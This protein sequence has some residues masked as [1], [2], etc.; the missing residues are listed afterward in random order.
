MAAIYDDDSD[1]GKFVPSEL[2]QL[3][4]EGLPPLMLIQYILGIVLTLVPITLHL[5]DAGWA[6]IC[7]A[8][9][10]MATFY[11][12]RRSRQ[13]AGLLLLAS[14]LLVWAMSLWLYPGDVAVW[15]ALL[16]VGEA[17][18]VF[19]PPGAFATSVLVSLIVVIAGSAGHVQAAVVVASSLLIWLNVGISWLAARPSTLSL[20]W[21]WSSYADARQSRDQLRH[22]QG[23]LNRVLKSL[24]LAYQRLEHLSEELN[25]ARQAAEEA[26]RLKGEFAASIS[27]ELRTPL[28]LIIG[29]AEMMLMGPRSRVI[30]GLP[31]TFQGDVEAIYRNACH[32]SS[33]VDDILDLSQIDAHRMGL[34]REPVMLAG[35]VEEATTAISTM[36]RDKGLS[37]SAEIPD[38]LPVVLADR[39]RVRQVLINLL[40]NAA[41]FTNDGGVTIRARWD[42]RD[43]VVSVAD[44]GVGLAPEDLP[45]L[46]DEFR[47]VGPQAS[48]HH[49]GLGLTICKR[50]VELHGG[51]I[52]VESRLGEGTTFHFSLPRAET[53]VS[54]LPERDWDA[55]TWN[56]PRETHPPRIAVL[57]DDPAVLR[58]FERYLDGYQVVRAR[59][60]KPLR[61]LIRGDGI[62]AVVVTNPDPRVV[63]GAPLVPERW[64]A[65]NLPIISCSLRTTRDA[66]RSLGVAQYLHKPISRE[67]IRAC[68]RHLGRPVRDVL[69][70]D[71]DPDMV[72]LLVRMVRSGFRRCRIVEAQTGLQALELL[73]QRRPDVV[74]LDLLMPGLDGYGVLEQMRSDEHLRDVPVVV[75]TAK[76][77]EDETVTARSLE[78]T[79]PGGLSVGEAMGCL[80]DCL[81]LL[82]GRGED[83][84]AP[85]RPA[86]PRA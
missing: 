20:E 47:Q 59:E 75:I 1:P 38:G 73:R 77:A 42:E 79:R 5:E 54:S 56:L 72:R 4:L 65:T 48:R 64:G 43:I 61:E 57:D 40:N 26:R 71:D 24:D 50:F 27:H 53:V 66:A 69:V 45:T 52:W 18:T 81:D 44:T 13:L 30:G 28:N 2:S 29:F 82:L 68:L 84:I 8:L 51:S 74:L 80:R 9:L 21:V 32:L 7:L 49:S 17:S 67:Q 60:G 34:R 12:Y 25:R 58:I 55:A 19:G 33:L 16:V 22:H 83:S 14:L 11:V 62:H 10:T 41:R 35:V 6:G 3:R 37:L 70:V 46:F 15:F 23:E 78:I 76:G 31:D 85:A 63:D 86:A 39:A 36:F